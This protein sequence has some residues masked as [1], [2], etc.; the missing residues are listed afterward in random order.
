MAKSY[1]RET[2]LVAFP[3]RVKQH[4]DGQWAAWAAW[5]HEAIY[6]PTAYSKFRSVVIRRC[7][8]NIERYFRKRQRER[9]RL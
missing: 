9:D 1:S 2:V 8:T 7:R 5:G 3:I 4:A 6:I